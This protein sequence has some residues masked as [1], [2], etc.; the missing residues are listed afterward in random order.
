MTFQDNVT[1]ASS[2]QLV[3]LGETAAAA[4]GQHR[5]FLAYLFQR[6]IFASA[7]CFV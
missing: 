7:S 4:I 1:A 3:S 2:G 5:L 6:L